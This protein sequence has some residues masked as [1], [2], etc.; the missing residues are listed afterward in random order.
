MDDILARPRV[1]KQINLSSIRRVIKNKGTV[2]RAEIAWETQIS[3]TTVRSL[4]TEMQ[5]SGEIESVGYAESSGGRKAEKYRFIP[6]C[7][8]GAA[9]CV[10]HDS[11][12]YLLVN[13]HGDIIE[14][15]KL[16]ALNSETNEPI[17][18]FMDDL[19]KKKEI[20]SIGLGVPGIV[21]EGS[22]WSG[23]H[24]DD[25]SRNDIGTFLTEKYGIPV[26]M[27]NDLNATAIG[28]C[29]SYEKHFSVSNSDD[30]NLALVFFGKDG[31]SAGLISG[32]RVVRGW[33]N[34]AGEFS[35]TP[36]GRYDEPF[37]SKPE[38]MSDE[39]FCAYVIRM[40]SCICAIINPQYITLAGAS[41]RENCLGR[42]N[43]GL[44]VVLP[45]G[46]HAEINYS[47]DDQCVF[48]EGMAY[49]TAERIFNE[50][51]LLKA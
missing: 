21:N 27:E 8:F 39:L 2:T 13:I 26:I 9:F 31:I 45:S 20:K 19:L 30:T 51:Q 36:Y 1:L 22:Y 5:R 3:S 33:K 14:I 32:G 29:R 17:T 24:G 16:D 48:F 44:S 40:L 43:E 49:L 34:F 15:E 7:Y 46:M 18:S 25:L 23:V 37:D 35:M 47:S 12:H 4:L 50:V 42:I 11:L 38:Q 6:D 10:T 41:F 28:Y